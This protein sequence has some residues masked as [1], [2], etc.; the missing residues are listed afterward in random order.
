M[1]YLFV[2]DVS[3]EYSLAQDGLTARTTAT[4]VGDRP[5]PY[6]TGQHPYP[7]LGTGLVDP[8]QLELDVGR[9]LPTDRRPGLAHRSRRRRRL[10]LPHRTTDRRTGHR[11][12]LHR[13]RSRHRRPGMG[14]RHR[15]RPD[16]GSAHCG[17]TQR[18]RSSR[19]HRPHPGRAALAHRPGRGTD[20]LRPNAFRSGDGLIRLIPGE[21]STSSWG[22]RSG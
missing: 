6:G 21:S 2:L 13:P 3:V 19:S 20:D 22:L 7:S 12:H 18:T 8:C 11:L 10:R 4:N 17:P 5:C 15:T 1:G 14:A 16:D 9:Q